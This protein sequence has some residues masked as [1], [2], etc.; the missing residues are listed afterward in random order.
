MRKQIQLDDLTHLLGRKGFDRKI[1]KGSHQVFTH[2]RSRTDVLLPLV[3]RSPRAMPT[4]VAAVRKTLDETG[5]MPREAFNAWM[6]Q[7]PRADGGSHKTKL[8]STTR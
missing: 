4:Y 5:L 7:P 1:V 8:A 2:G 3:I 6:H